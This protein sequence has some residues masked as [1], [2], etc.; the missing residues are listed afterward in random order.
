MSDRVPAEA[1][2]PGDYLRDELD[3]R[4]W[5]QTEFAE[6]LGR[7]PRVVNEI[8]AGK[9][10]VTP[11][12][13]KELA[14]ALGTSAQFWMNLE[15]AYQLS[16]VD[17]V[18]E[19]I[20]HEAKLREKY[21]VRELVKRGW[22]VESENREVLQARVLQFFGVRSVDEAPAYPH[23]ARRSQQS[24]EL[25][26]IQWAWLFRVKHL[27][28]SFPSQPYSET[29]LRDSLS[30]LAAL[31]AE[32]EEA[33]HVPRI[34]A[35]CGVRFVIVEPVPGSKI[36]GVCFWINNA[37]VPV[38]GM[39]LRFD[40]IDNFW[41]VLR[42]EIEHVLQGHGKSRWIIDEDTGSTDGAVDQEELLA[43]AAAESFCV[44]RKDMDDFIARVRPFFSEEKIIR[45]ARRIKRH[46][47]IVIGQLQK[48]LD[49][50]D[51]LKKHQVKIRPHVIGSALTDGWGRS[52]PAIS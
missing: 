17:P 28:S 2:P 12:T 49:R 23:A 43:D 48:R 9:R 39:T 1:F 40:R 21:P 36:D 34:L 10:S 47:G 33:R 45:F 14:A 52:A 15:T 37:Q 29:K 3:E 30:G 27:A 19:R 11:E 38:I 22:I 35:D 6:I 26:P 25:N 24:V 42:H 51:L 4:G 41:Y 32:P 8:I 7:P 18:P 46:P 16:R 50:Y 44:A 20:S 31:A 13:A 5:T